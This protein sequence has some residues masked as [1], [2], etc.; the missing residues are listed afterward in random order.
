MNRS[1]VAKTTIVAVLGCLVL[2]LFIAACARKKPRSEGV[3]TYTYRV[4]R[5]LPHD[6]QAFTQGFAFAGGFFYESTGL[7]GKSSLRRLDARTGA[8]L[9]VIPLDAR[10][11]GEGLAVLSNRLIQLTWREHTG[12]VYEVE[13]LKQIRS[14][15][16]EVEG[17]GL[18]TD[19]QRL[20]LSD[21]SA[22][23]RLLDPET[24]RETSRV[25]VRDR[26]GPV[27]GLNELEY[28][29]GLV[30]ANVWPTEQIAMIDLES[31]TIRG[32][33][34]L[35]GLAERMEGPLD[36]ANGIAFDPAE[37]RLYVTGKFWPRIF[38]IVLHSR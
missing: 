4:V 2:A 21:G 30:F 35:H 25:A 31:G 29:N 28:V 13:S 5:E 6:R 11:F 7:Y 12:L 36:V 16:Y 3:Q 34:D 23:L 19:G 37:K 9:A 15:T 18:T 14:F 8:L 1:E 32:W 22:T 27:S 20:I 17:W 33:I 10:Y 24:F 38:E 26:R